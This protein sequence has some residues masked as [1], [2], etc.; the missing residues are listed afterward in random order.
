MVGMETSSDCELTPQAPFARRFY[1]QKGVLMKLV[2]FS[3]AMALAPIGT[4]FG[5]LSYFDGA[6]S[7]PVLPSSSSSPVP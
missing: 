1:R 5:S 2:G 3:I 4:Y 7:S 6:C